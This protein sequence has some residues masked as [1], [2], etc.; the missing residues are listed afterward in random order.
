[1]APL[2]AATAIAAAAGLA[3]A[4]YILIGLLVA[5]RFDRKITRHHQRD[6]AFHAAAIAFTATVD[7]AMPDTYMV[8]EISRRL[9]RMDRI[10]ELPTRRLQAVFADRFQQAADAV[11]ATTLWVA[12]PNEN[13]HAELQRFLATLMR[14]LIYQA[15]DHLPLAPPSTPVARRRAAL[16][17]VRTAVIGLLPAAALLALRLTGVDLGGAAATAKTVAIIWAAVT[18]LILIDP[19]LKERLDT[20]KNVKG[21]FSGSKTGD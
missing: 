2:V 3:G 8:T 16:S 5:T 21:L 15:Y 17:V 12:L 7:R 13:T 20:V 6:V 14:T 18:F 9:R 19:N 11:L 10:H 1:V 4:V